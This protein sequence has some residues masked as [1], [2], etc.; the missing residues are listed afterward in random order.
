MPAPVFSILIFSK[1]VFG[2]VTFSSALF[3]LAS[4]FSPDSADG[5]IG[6]YEHFDLQNPVLSFG[7]GLLC[8]FLGIVAAILINL[9]HQ[10]VSGR[11]VRALLKS[12]ASSAD[13]AKTPAELTLP[14]LAPLRWALRYALRD[15]SYLRKTVCRVVP[16]AETA[17]PKAFATDAAIYAG[18]AGSNAL[19]TAAPSAAVQ[20]SEGLSIHESGKEPGSGRAAKTENRI[21]LSE[22]RFY[23][24]EENRFRAEER[25]KKKGNDWPIAVIAILLFGLAFWLIW[26][27]FPSMLSL[28]DNFL[29]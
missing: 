9:W 11:F 10:S 28:L 5:S 29:D 24:P 18:K 23:I 26:K 6:T 13:T 2:T 20:T 17:N 4:F 8:L 1:E 16:S 27:N 12:G 25:W 19:K 15:G 7:A 22:T 14:R 3:S 21:S